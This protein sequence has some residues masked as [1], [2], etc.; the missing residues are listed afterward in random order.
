MDFIFEKHRRSFRNGGD[1]NEIQ[2][3]YNSRLE[4]WKR[5]KLPKNTKVQDELIKEIV[6]EIKEDWSDE[7]GPNAVRAKY[8]N[9]YKMLKY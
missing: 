7:Y 6:P 1:L 3:L 2:K 9:W 4:S 8:L 5:S